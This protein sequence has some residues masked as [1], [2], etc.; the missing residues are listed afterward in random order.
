MLS[1]EKPGATF[2]VAREP[3]APGKNP[4]LYWIF[5]TGFI[6]D[7]PWDPREWHWRPNPP[8]GDFPFFGYTAKRGYTNTHKTTHTSN[9]QAFLQGLNLRN[10]TN[11]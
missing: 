6:Q 2:R 1:Q 10:T 3:P 4:L 9:M 5:E 7:L 11:S 8:L